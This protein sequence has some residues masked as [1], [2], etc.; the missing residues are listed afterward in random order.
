MQFNI[1][2][3]T[4]G[5]CRSAVEA[6]VKSVDTQAKVDVDLDAKTARIETG[7]AE[8]EVA[9]AIRDAGYTVNA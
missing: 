5:H 2:D 3:M 9:Q 1:P 8:A 7:A 6:A 4:C